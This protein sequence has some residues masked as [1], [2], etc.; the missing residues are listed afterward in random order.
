MSKKNNSTDF[1]SNRQAFHNYEVLETLEAGIA[2]L[3]SEVKSL[4]DGGGALQ[5][6]Y[7]IIKKNEAWLKNASIAP[8]KFSNAFGHEERRDRKLLLH[9]YEIEKL[10]KKTETKGFTLIGLALYLKNGFVKVKVGI[11]RGKKAHDK[12]ESLKA[13]E[14]KREIAR[15]LKSN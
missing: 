6:N 7:I 13:K 12:R 9:K 2:L 10:R 11:C 1:V 8:Y 5:D 15:A 4:R 3:G 14:Q